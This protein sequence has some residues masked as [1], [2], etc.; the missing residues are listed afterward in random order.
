MAPDIQ[1]DAEFPLNFAALA[2]Q[3][4]GYSATDLQDFVARAV[5][6]AAI[7]SVVKNTEGAEVMHSDRPLL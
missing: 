4:E 5:H 3:T 1:Q 6:Q 2:T 7:R